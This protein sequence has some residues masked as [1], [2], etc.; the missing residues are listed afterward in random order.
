MEPSPVSVE[1][2]GKTL[3]GIHGFDLG[4][5]EFPLLL[6]CQLPSITDW[7]VKLPTTLVSEPA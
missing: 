6:L 2:N 7:Y 5:T 4:R 3:F 1:V